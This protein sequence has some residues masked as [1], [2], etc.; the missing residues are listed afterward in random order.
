MKAVK[1]KEANVDFA[2]GQD[3]YHTLP[4]LRFGDKNDTIVTCYSLTLTERL[5]V[6]FTGKIW[7]SEINFNRSLTPRYFSVNQKDVFTTE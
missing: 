3:E 2:K 1:F 7:M 4:A 5:K 6:L